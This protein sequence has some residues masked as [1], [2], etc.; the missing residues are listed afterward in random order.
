MQTREPAER[1]VTI[2]DVAAQAGVAASTVSR[3]LNNPGRVNATTRERV[4]RIAAELNYVPSSQARALS[5]GRTRT[6]ALLVPDITNPFYFDLIRGTQH[7]LKAAGYSQVLLDTE[8][9][10][11]QESESLERLRKTCDGVILTA[12]RLTDEQIVAASRLHPLVTVNR[13][14]HGV[15]SVLLDVPAAI[16]QALDH[17]VSLGHRRICYV[18]GPPNSFSNR[19]RWRA[20]N[21]AI[22]SRQRPGGVKIE[23]VRI[24]PFAPKTTSGAGAADAVINTNATA[25]IAYNDLLAIGMLRR[26][27]ERGLSVP[28]DVSIV[29]CDDIFGADFCNPPLTTMTAPIEQA[30]RAATTM[31]LGL[32]NPMTPGQ[33]SPRGGERRVLLPTHLTVRSTT[34][35]ARNDIP[36][37]QEDPPL[38]ASE[39]GQQ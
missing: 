32:L 13:N 23:A 12:S 31:M 7:Q 17:L 19:W 29:G 34:G 21:E 33:V 36:A 25:A 27:A 1:S 35:P 2:H 20:L 8:E 16:N 38:R 5:S 22:R 4:Q 26:M 24:G 39:E 6:V 37:V 28:D 10:A 30:G 14:V 3:A 15:P 18:S 9:S 11:G